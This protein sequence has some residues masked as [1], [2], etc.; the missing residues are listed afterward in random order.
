MGG[1]AVTSTTPLA[2]GEAV[3]VEWGG[4]WWKATVVDVK[5][6]DKPDGNV[7]IHYSGW[8]SQ[9]DEIVPLGRLRK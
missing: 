9:W 4:S 6:H 7:K 1:E 5:P 3:L 2:V 8:E